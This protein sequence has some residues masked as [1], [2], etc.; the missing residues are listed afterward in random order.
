MTPNDKNRPADAEASN[1]AEV[2][3]TRA[4]ARIRR[5]MAADLARLYPGTRWSD[6]DGNGTVETAADDPGGSLAEPEDA[7]PPVID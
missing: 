2:S 5:M 3:L 1:R 6:S 4:R 7:E